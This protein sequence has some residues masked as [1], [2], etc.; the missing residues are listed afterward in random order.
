MG[1]LAISMPPSGRCF[2]NHIEVNFAFD[3]QLFNGEKTEK[4][5]GKRLNQAKKRGQFAKSRELSSAFIL[6]FGFFILHIMGKFIF[7]TITSFM[8]FTYSNLPA[9][10]T[11]EFLMN[12]FLQVSVVLIKTVFPI[13]VAI[14][15][16]A[17]I[18]NIY[19]VGLNFN[20]QPFGFKLSKFNPLAGMKRMV[21][22]QALVELVKEIGRAHV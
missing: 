3:L 4:P 9:N 19:Q 2:D 20:T 13:M 7:E 16:V 21:N 14:S 18:I 17:I 15:L 6:F 10:I 11:T 5:T 1:C 12:L 22:L 8:K